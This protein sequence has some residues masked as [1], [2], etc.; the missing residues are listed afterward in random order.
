[1][2]THIRLKSA[3]CLS[4]QRPAVTP[5]IPRHSDQP[6]IGVQG[7]ALVQS[8]PELPLAA[9]RSVAEGAA[10]GLGAAAAAAAAARLRQSY[11]RGRAGRLGLLAGDGGRHQTRAQLQVT[12]RRDADVK[13]LPGA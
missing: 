11:G 12:L 13:T 1:M 4:S 9:L 10:V 6:L 2:Q 3:A 8:C 5:P 7:Q